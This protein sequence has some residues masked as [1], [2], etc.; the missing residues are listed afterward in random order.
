MR[1]MHQQLR[2]ASRMHFRTVRGRRVSEGGSLF[3]CSCSRNYSRSMGDMVQGRVMRVLEL[4]MEAFWSISSN[5]LDV[6]L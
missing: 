4:V 5:V 3:V 1:R 6:I 2:A